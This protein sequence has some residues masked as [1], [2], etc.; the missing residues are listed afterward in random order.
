MLGFLVILK[1]LGVQ[2]FVLSAW[3][4]DLSQV[5]QIQGMSAR[6]VLKSALG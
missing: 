1:S 3:G 2:I 6:Q 5:H 4:G